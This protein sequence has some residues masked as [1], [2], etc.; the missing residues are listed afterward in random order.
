MVT[1][2][3]YAPLYVAK[4]LGLFGDV[5]VNLLRI[6]SIGDLR[7]ALLAKRIDIYLASFDIFQ[8]IEGRAP[9]GK[10]I[11]AIDES[12]GAD[13]IV[14]D[15]SIRRVGDLVGKKVGVEPGFP[16]HFVLTYQLFKAGLRLSDLNVI[17]MPSG[18]I[19]SAFAANQIEVGATYEPFLSTCLAQRNGAKVIASSA[20][21][22]GLITDFMVASEDA[23]REKKDS[24]KAVIRGWNAALAKISE[25]PNATNEIM[26]KAF[27]VPA[28]EMAEFAT[29]VKW[30]GGNENQAL[31]NGGQG[32][33]FAGRF[34]E[35][36]EALRL[37]NSAIYQ[38]KIVD[39]VDLSFLNS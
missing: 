23:I 1:F 37:N 12:V 20:D 26:G 27:G 2:P 13:G 5:N 19:P 9:I 32:S 34:N 31:F 18:D 35:V 38:A 28:T 39:S 10:M 16:P 7:S 17:D 21:T 25:S 30:L 11:Y 8:S 6:E 36:N 14:A 24:L 33:L 3:G 29:V 22:P 4:E 15:G